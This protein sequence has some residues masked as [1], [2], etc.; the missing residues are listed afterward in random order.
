MR[1]DDS[2]ARQPPAQLGGD[3]ALVARVAEREEEAD[4]DRLGVDLA[5]RLE[6]ERPEHSFRTD[7][8]GDAEAALQRHQ[9]LGMVRHRAGRDALASAGGDGGGARIPRFAT[10]AVRAPLRSS[11]AF[12]ATVVPC[13]KRSTSLG[14]DRAGRGEHGLL[15]ARRGRHLRRRDP[16][17]VDEDGVRESAAYVD[18]ENAHL[19]NVRGAKRVRRDMTELKLVG[20]GGEPVDLRRTIASHGV[21]DLP[22]NRIDEDAWTLELTLPVDGK[23]PR[24][25]VVS[26]GRPGY[27]KV[28]VRGR[29]PSAA[30]LDRLRSRVAHVLRLDEDLT[31]FYEVAA[32][33][34]D[35]AWVT[36]GAGR[37]LRSPTVFE[38]VVKT[39]CTTNCTWSATVRMVTALV[40]S[41][42][43]PGADADGPFGRAFPTP[44]AMAGRTVRFTLKLSERAIAART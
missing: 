27:A 28:E 14:A 31:P 35:L 41:L 9:R 34:P 20:A 3:G 43:E 42:G 30:D 1:C 25:V 4:G 10:K 26:E 17:L 15:L 8:L 38:D 24:T 23:A 29:K 33:D 40:E 16:A 37:L 13:V 22:P 21:A 18:A 32:K 6:I 5:Q 2:R 12:V 19:A 44:E 39:I 11:S 7:P 36:A